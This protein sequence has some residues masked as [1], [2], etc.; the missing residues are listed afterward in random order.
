MMII[1]KCT[2]QRPAV[3][4]YSLSTDPLTRSYRLVPVP[5]LNRLSL[6]AGKGV[7]TG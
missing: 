7:V 2:L 5:S 4:E 6:R 3:D 1:G